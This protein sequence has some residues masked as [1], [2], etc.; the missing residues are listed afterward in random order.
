MKE[1]KSQKIKELEIKIDSARW[2][3]LRN[4]ETVFY[5]QLMMN[6][7]DVIT[8]CIPTAATDGKR[9]LWNPDFLEART[10]EEVRFILIHETDHC[11]WGHFWRF[12]F[13]TQPKANIACDHAINLSLLNIQNIKMPDMALADPKYKNLSE[14]EIYKLLPDPITIYIDICGGMTDGEGGDDKDGEGK[15]GE[16]KDG[17]KKDKKSRSGGKIDKQELKEEWV[18]KVIQAAQIAKTL[19]QGTLPAELER[20]LQK[21]LAQPVNWKAETQDFVKNCVSTKNDYTRSNKRNAWQPVITPRKKRDC[22]SRIVFVRDTS[23][24]VGDRELG[25][26]NA[27]IEQGMGET[28][29]SA[30]VIDCDANIAAMYEINFGMEVPNTAKGGGGTDFRPPFLE[31]KKRIE[32]GEQ[33]AGLVYITD[34][35]GSQVEP[36]NYPEF[37]VL[38]LSITENFVAPFG[39][40]VFIDIS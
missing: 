7:R 17:D 21:E 39:R 32:D 26:F 35:F 30:V 11:A 16:G 23:G 27:L 14:E 18:R 13:K 4:K 24:S 25:V 37:P 10:P 12:D 15:D 2:W 22:I 38:W 6:L 29:C 34:G 9:I 31:C 19:S 40:T 3:C 5:G 28:G 36:Q 33:I 20:M 8:N 1:L